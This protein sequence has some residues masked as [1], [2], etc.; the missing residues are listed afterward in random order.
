MGKEDAHRQKDGQPL[1]NDRGELIEGKRKKRIDKRERTPTNQ[2][3]QPISPVT[4]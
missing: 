1:E 3:E 4:K 2:L